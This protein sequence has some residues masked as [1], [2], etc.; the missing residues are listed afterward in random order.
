MIMYKH[1]DLRVRTWKEIHDAELALIDSG[2]KRDWCAIWI[3]VFC[4]VFAADL[5]INLIRI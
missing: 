4:F 5:V 3:Y 1:R 2:H